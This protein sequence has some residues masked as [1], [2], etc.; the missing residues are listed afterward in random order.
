MMHVQQPP[1]GIKVIVGACR[2]ATLSLVG[3]SDRRAEAVVA[4]AHGWFATVN[5]SDE[6]TGP[7]LMP[8]HSALWLTF[9]DRIQ[10]IA[11]ED[12]HSRE[13]PWPT[14]VLERE[15]SLDLS[16]EN[17]IVHRNVGFLES[18]LSIL[19]SSNDTEG[20]WIDVPIR[21]RRSHLIEPKGWLLSMIDESTFFTLDGAGNI[22]KF[23]LPGQY[24]IQDSH[25]EQNDR[26]WLSVKAAPTH[27]VDL[28][29]DVD[30]SGSPP[31]PRQTVLVVT[32]GRVSSLPAGGMCKLA[33][34]FPIAGRPAAICYEGSLV[35]ED[36]GGDE[37]FELG[38]SFRLPFSAYNEAREIL[39]PP[40]SKH[41]VYPRGAE[42]KSAET[43]DSPTW[44]LTDGY[45]VNNEIVALRAAAGGV[46]VARR[47]FSGA[48]APSGGV[49]GADGNV[50][51]FHDRDGALSRFVPDWSTGSIAVEALPL[52]VAPRRS[53]NPQA[54]FGDSAVAATAKG[55]LW[56]VTETG[57]LAW[58]SDRGEIALEPESSRAPAVDL[59]TRQGVAWTLRKDGALAVATNENMTVNIFGEIRAGGRPHVSSVVPYGRDAQSAV[60]VYRD[61]SSGTFRSVGESRMPTFG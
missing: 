52:H 41:A 57:R 4:S 42:C 1:R 30:F 10:A 29:L 35:L 17:A 49:V 21:Y 6:L 25:R 40:L 47:P 51:W 33:P 3:C 31:N 56:A 14:T 32:H 5:P 54:F 2:V 46:E 7:K 15:L 8:S 11:L 45:G 48:E 9:D 18:D 39:N 38:K 36:V 61:G 20:A 26:I 24:L 23:T 34:C 43:N 59:W 44:L 19:T 12:G 50:M 58:V 22:T 55:G 16:G 13:W 37:P 27:G 28:D 60:V 53:Q